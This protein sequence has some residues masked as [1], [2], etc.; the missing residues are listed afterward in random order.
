MKYK[1]HNFMEDMIRD[2]MAAVLSGMPSVCRCERCEMDRLAIAL[3]K[4]PPKYVVSHEGTMYARVSQLQAQ[5]DV[6]IVRATTSAAML[7]EQNPRHD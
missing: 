2:K 4:M 7:V 3:N 1:L 6:D 5:F